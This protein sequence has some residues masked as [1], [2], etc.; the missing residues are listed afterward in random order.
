[1]KCL[2]LAILAVLIAS[3]CSSCLSSRQDQFGYAAMTG[4]VSSARQFH[5]PGYAR[6]RIYESN[7][8]KSVPIQYAI[9]QRNR[10]MATFLVENGCHTSINGQNLAYYCAANGYDGMARHFAGL[11][12]G[13]YADIN[14]A[15]QNK[16]RA[17]RSSNSGALIALGVL[18]ML[19][20]S[21]A[22]S[23][24]SS[25]APPGVDP[26]TWRGFQTTNSAAYGTR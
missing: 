22:G 18:A 21:S 6:M 1:M 25:D 17:Q 4:N 2:K 11:G 19:I 3:L 7:G 14:R 9:V 26:T 15:K 24:S 5:Q 12:A 13:S 10:E 23:A 8:Q 16:A 20:N